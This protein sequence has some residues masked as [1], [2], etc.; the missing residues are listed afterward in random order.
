MAEK[1]SI[2][3]HT[4]RLFDSIVN[5]GNL[6][7][8]CLAM[9]YVKGKIEC[10]GT[11]LIQDK[12]QD[13]LKPTDCNCQQGSSIVDIFRKEQMD[14][15][16]SVEDTFDSEYINV[17]GVLNYISNAKPIPKLLANLSLMN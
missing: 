9:V 8:P 15:I 13:M 3:R 5:L 14:L 10:F 2:D 12:V 7:V 16:T 17:L 6:K 1:K 11:K 4:K